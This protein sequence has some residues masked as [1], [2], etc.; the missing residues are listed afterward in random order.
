MIYGSSDLTFADITDG[1]SQTI[2][3]GE[4]SWEVDKL[5]RTNFDPSPFGPW[6]VGSTS[7]NGPDDAV[8]GSRG[9]VQNAKN[10]RYAINERRLVDENGTPTS[11]LTDVSLGSNHPGGTHVGMCDGAGHF[12]NEDVDTDV[13][14]AMASRKAG[15]IYE[16]PF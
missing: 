16:K 9:Y 3:Y 4:L 10:L 13:L 14:R 8:N 5:D 11:T 7:I 2:M 1:T 6:I 15:E 12:I